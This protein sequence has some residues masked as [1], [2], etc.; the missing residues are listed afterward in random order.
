MDKGVTKVIDNYI[1]FLIDKQINIKKAYLFG[2][3]AKSKETKYSDIDIALV[4]DNADIP[5]RFD[6]QVQLFTLAS[7]I[8]NRIEPHPMNIDEFNNDNP[9]ASEIIKT[10]REI[11]INLPATGQG[12]TR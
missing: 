12:F 8:D 10:G 3:Y 4:F 5:D 1:N 2:S 6:L 9:F 11:K 7:Y